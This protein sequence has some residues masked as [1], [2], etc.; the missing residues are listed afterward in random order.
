MF[1]INN[2]TYYFSIIFTFFPYLNLLSSL[3]LQT[4][5]PGPIYF[6]VS[7][8][9]LL[10]LFYIFLPHILLVQPTIFIGI[11]FFF[12][13]LSYHYL[14]FIYL[15]HLYLTSFLRKRKS[16]LL[17]FLFT[18]YYLVYLYFLQSPVLA[19]SP[20]NLLF[21][22]LFILLIFLVI[23]YTFYLLIYLT[24]LLCFLLFTTI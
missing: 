10:S 24:P 19:A 7:Y 17:I 9:L 2:L 1:L 12:L 21:L 15:I 23:T 6:H 16:F 3:Q 20:D 18:L 22:L 8:C 5:F 14:S 4:V 11:R 13:L